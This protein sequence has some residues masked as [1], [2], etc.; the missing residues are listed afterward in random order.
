M[1]N[2]RAFTYDAAGNLTNV[3][4]GQ[5]S[6]CDGKTAGV[7]SCNAYQGNPSGTCGA[8]ST[9]SCT[10]AAAGELC[11]TQDG[12]GNRTSYAY[13]TNH[14]LASISPPSPLGGTSVTVD[15]LSRVT[16]V[17]DGKGQKTTYS[18]DALDRVTQILYGGTTSCSSSSTCTTIQYDPDGN[19]TSR[20][21]ASGTTGFGYDTMNRLTKKTLPSST[22]NCSGQTGITFAYDGVGN[23]TSYCDAGGSVSYTYDTVNRVSNLAEPGGTCSGT[24]SLCTTFSYDND[25]RLTKLTFPGGATESLTYD[26]AGNETSVIGKDSSNNVLTSISYG[27]AQATQ[28]KGLRLSMTENDPLANLATSYTSILP[29]CAQIGP[30]LRTASPRACGRPRSRPSSGSARCR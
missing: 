7:N 24:P 29:Q 17:T 19:L 13:D 10:N 4:D 30:R 27:Y 23:L 6:G 14:N 15:S 2:C 12:K 16:S 26:G 21:D 11:W 22:W 18:Y 8:T 9:V 5:A 20:T 3:Y 1:G 28:D 25:N